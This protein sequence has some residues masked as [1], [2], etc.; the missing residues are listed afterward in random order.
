M[1]EMQVVNI[2][3]KFIDDSEEDVISIYAIQCLWTLGLCVPQWM[4]HLL[5]MFLNLTTV[6]HAETAALSFMPI[7]SNHILNPQDPI[8]PQIKE[9]L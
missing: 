4:H 5:S 7:Y 8:S 9:R 1:K 3:R 2:L 6:A